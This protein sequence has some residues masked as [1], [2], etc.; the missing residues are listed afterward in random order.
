[1]ALKTTQ[2]VRDTLR[3]RFPMTL[4][5]VEMQITD[6]PARVHFPVQE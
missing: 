5:K 3:E 1:M 4:S 2:R 6:D